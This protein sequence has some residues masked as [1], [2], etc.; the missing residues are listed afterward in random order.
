MRVSVC[1]YGMAEEYKAFLENLSLPSFPKL[2][3]AARR[4]NEW[5][6]RSSKFGARAKPS[7]IL[8]GRCMQRKRP[9]TWPTTMLE[10][11]D[12]LARRD[13]LTKGVW[14]LCLVDYLCGEERGTS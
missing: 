13:L 1:L 2:M 6:H 5:V 14:V 10:R 12:H 11:P 4:T 9:S 3:E 8:I 7:E